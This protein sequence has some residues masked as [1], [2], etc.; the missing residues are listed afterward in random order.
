MCAQVA[1]GH[2]LFWLLACCSSLS[3]SALPSRYIVVGGM[4]PQL[5][6]GH[7]CMSSSRPCHQRDDHPQDLQFLLSPKVPVYIVS[8]HAQHRAE[9]LCIYYGVILQFPKIEALV[10]SLWGA[11]RKP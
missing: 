7:L 1:C 2:L 11:I 10:P 3:C 9:I 6:M 4:S 8:C 5:L